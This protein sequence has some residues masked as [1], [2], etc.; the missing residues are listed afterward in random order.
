MIDTCIV[1]GQSFPLLSVS[2]AITLIFVIIKIWG[3]RRTGA[4]KLHPRRVHSFIHI[5]N[6]G[7]L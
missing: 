6:A 2:D 7:G 4:N 3:T 5:G 1:G